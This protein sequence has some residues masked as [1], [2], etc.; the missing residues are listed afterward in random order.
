M[1]F[2]S[3]SVNCNIHIHIHMHIYIRWCNLFVIL[4]VILLPCCR[5]KLYIYIV[6]YC[7]YNHGYNTIDSTTS[8]SSPLL[9]SPLLSSP[10]LSSPST[11]CSTAAAITIAYS[12]DGYVALCV[13]T[14]FDSGRTVRQ[15]STI[16]YEYIILSL[17]FSS[18][19]WF[20]MMSSGISM[21]TSQSC[22][23]LLLLLVSFHSY[24]G[25]RDRDRDRD[26]D[27]GRRRRRRP[28]LVDW[29]IWMACYV[30]SFVRSFRSFPSFFSLYLV[31]SFDFSRSFHFI[32]FY[33]HINPWP[34]GYCCILN[35][36][37]RDVTCLRR[38]NVVSMNE[39]EWSFSKV[40][41]E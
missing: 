22:H 23:L 38:H 11:T 17:F 14:R 18:F 36:A 8:P 35:L 34:W 6:R 39:C 33:I 15:Y 41:V 21:W 32:C 20:C 27:D 28:S 1:Y 5:H 31:D 3:S 19:L 24:R 9:S 7:K 16:P 29:Y 37:W 4:L 13:C 12:I 40:K 2:I 25:R 30:C 26:C 10:L